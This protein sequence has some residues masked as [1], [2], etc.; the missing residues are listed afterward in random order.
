MSVFTTVGFG[1]IHA[2]TD[3]ARGIVT[4]QMV[5]GFVLIGVGARILFAVGRRAATATTTDP[6]PDA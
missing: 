6:N 1:D 5:L 3:P 2:A 4:A